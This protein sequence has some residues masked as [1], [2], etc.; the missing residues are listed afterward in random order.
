M[1]ANATTSAA[2]ITAEECESFV[3]PVR[4]VERVTERSAGAL[5]DDARMTYTRDEARF[6]QPSIDE[7]VHDASVCE[8]IRTDARVHAFFTWQTT[9]EATC[10]RTPHVRRVEATAGAIRK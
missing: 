2:S 8:A 6:V 7:P 9:S 10:R 3:E 5:R 1:C 4:L